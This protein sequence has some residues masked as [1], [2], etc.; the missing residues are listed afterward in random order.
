MGN[1]CVIIILCDKSRKIGSIELETAKDE[2]N[3]PSLKLG[4]GDSSGSVKGFLEKMEF[5][6]RH[7]CG[8]GIGQAWE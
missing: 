8:V 2:Y 1:I 3:L 4:E 7:D 5:K 6:L